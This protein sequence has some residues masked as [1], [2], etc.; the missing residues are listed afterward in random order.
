MA[1]LAS[2]RQGGHGVGL[3]FYFGLTV[4]FLAALALT[5]TAYH[6]HGHGRRQLNGSSLFEKKTEQVRIPPAYD[7]SLTRAF[8]CLQVP[9]DQGHRIHNH[10]TTGNDQQ[11][12]YSHLNHTSRQR[13]PATTTAYGSTAS[14][15]FSRSEFFHLSSLFRCSKGRIIPKATPGDALQNRLPWATPGMARH[16]NWLSDGHENCPD[17]RGFSGVPG[18]CGN[19]GNLQCGDSCF[20]LP[21]ATPGMARHENWHSDGHENCPDYWWWYWPLDTGSG[22]WL[23]QSRTLA[24]GPGNTGYWLLK[25]HSKSSELDRYFK[26]SYHCL[27]YTNNATPPGQNGYSVQN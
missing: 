3:K 11:C 16:E 18:F 23:W 20:R 7:T 4:T 8:P 14:D 2:A 12:Y 10:R 17:Y 13:L 24:T 21:W 19:P 6:H 5:F 22:Y 15:L 26:Y 27:N 1:D 25:S 9:S